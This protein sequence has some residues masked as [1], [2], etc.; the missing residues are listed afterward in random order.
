LFTANPA[1]EGV[2]RARVTGAARAPSQWC[3]VSPP[4]PRLSGE[5]PRIHSAGKVVAAAASTGAALVSIFSFL[6]SYGVIG[7]SESHQTI[8]NLGA[9]WVGV[10]PASDTATAIGDTVHLA[11]TITDKSGSILVGA[12]PAWVGDNPKV[13]S[14]LR[15]G[16]VIAQGP[17]STT[18]T[19]TVG[20]LFA[21]SRIF[22]KQRVTS[23][24]V[25]GIAGDTTPVVPEGE[26]RPLIAVPRDARGHAVAGLTAQWHVD[27]STVASLDS[28]GVATGRVA[29]RTIVSALVEGVSGH[30]AVNV[31]A[32]AAAIAQIAGAAQRAAAGSLLPQAVVVRVTS[33]RGRPVE[34]TLV[35]FRLADG[36]GSVE[37]EAAL[38]DA[39]GRA[40]S[41]WTL[42]DLPGRQTLL[43]SVERVDSALAVVAE[44][45]PVA[46]NTRV[47]SLSE[48]LEGAAGQPLADTVAIRITDSTGR[49]LPDVPVTWLALDGGSVEPIGART[50]SL[51]QAHARW[52]LGRRSGSQR[53]RAQVGSGHGGRAIPPLTITATAL[54]GEP[55]GIIVL[56]GDGQR[57]AAGARLPKPIVVQVVDA[58]GNGVAD[59]ALVLSPSAGSV[60]DTA[61]QADSVGVARI[62][63]TLGHSAGD[64]ALAVHIDG[65]KK[66]LKL[67]ARAVPATPANLSFDDAPPDG[68]TTRAR[69]KPLLAIVTDAFGNP[70]PDARVSF[71]TKS[72]SVSPS[73]AVSDAKGRVHVVWTP[74]G[75]KAGEQVVTGSVL[76]TDVKGSFVAQAAAGSDVR[77]AGKPTA[78]PPVP[79]K[80]TP[81]KAPIAK[82]APTRPALTRPASTK[83]MSS[84]SSTKP[85]AA[86]SAPPKTTKK[87]S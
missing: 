50:D 25:V 54:A 15:D 47:A 20:E 65:V 2:A 13:A 1:A 8:G 62:K 42:G 28:A 53:V 75:G 80:S 48:K 85:A 37:P 9:A 22:V 26:A 58:G 41:V 34:G 14:V 72:G 5:K 35:K 57:G 77:Q 78:E 17:G 24:D 63:W 71:F 60:P 36:Q 16:S 83:P 81:L 74:G 61:L 38:T 11:A 18:I 70:V 39:D 44:A 4:I 64:H 12:K 56:S 6:Y 84:S 51:G 7:K 21:R 49:A 87:R 55:V 68:K 79:A 45:E 73:R 69:S 30:T 59:A 27:D 67:T 76:D 3:M 40:R 31:V 43:A 19:V 46:G 66:L 52:L 29:G 23:V 82:T 32:T 10:R 33:R 86:K